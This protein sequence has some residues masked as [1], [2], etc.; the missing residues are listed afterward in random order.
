MQVEPDKGDPDWV[1]PGVFEVTAGIY[2]IPL[3]LPMD[4]LKAVNI[5]ALADADGIVLVDSGWAIDQARTALDTA[6]DAL[7]R[8]LRD[9]RRFLV[10]HVHRDH[11][12]LAV[13]VRRELGNRVSL[14]LGEKANV[15]L[16]TSP[17]RAPLGSQITQLTR[18]GA[19]E[20]CDW[21]VQRARSIGHDPSKWQGPDDWLVDGQQVEA[22]D[23]TLRVVATPGHTR[24]HVVFVD[25]AADLMFTGDHVLPHITPSIGFEGA[26][27]PLPLGD[28]M[29][30]LR[31]VRQLPDRRMLPAHGPVRSSVHLRID[32]LL[33]HHGH[34]LEQAS[35][36]VGVTDATGFEVAN[37]LTWTRRARAFAELDPFN[38]MLAVTETLAH[39]DVL[40]V[41]RRLAVTVDDQGVCH[42]SPA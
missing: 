1:R 36:A 24:G 3:P 14:G 35:A 11:Y 4:G 20:L 23:R 21:L 42:F 10:T 27:G 15:D 40:V 28:F 7:G 5:Y 16:L 25:E 2:R 41:Q 6:L 34:R 26:P 12:E 31:L 13:T 19:A 18:A 17:G 32:E 8:E 9:V 39:L 37:R 22:S 30:S 38:Q 33:D 29:D